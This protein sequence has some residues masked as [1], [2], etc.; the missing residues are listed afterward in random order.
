MAITINDLARICKVSRGTVDRAL[1]D[2]GGVSERTREKIRKA[3]EEYGYTP[4]YIASSLATGRSRSV[5]IIVFDLNN[6]FFTEVVSAAEHEFLRHG[7]F[8]YICLSLKDRRYEQ[9]LIADLVRRKA[10]GILFLP[11]NEG[12]EFTQYLK[13][14]PVPLVAISNRING[15]PY[16]G[17]D[18]DRAVGRGMECFYQRG[19]RKVHFVCPPL[20][21]LGKENLYSQ[22][23]R[24]E[25]Y[26]AYREAHPDMQG[27]EIMGE[28]YLDQVFERAAGDEGR[29]GFFCSSDHYALKIIK[30][31]RDRGVGIPSRFSLMGFDGVDN[32]LGHLERQLTTISYPAAEIG[33]RA[34]SALV[35]QI[36]GS[37]PQSEILL[38]CPLIP[39]ETV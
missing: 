6:R 1:H 16:I 10:D 15:L 4:N 30:A 22:L 24:L 23:R 27:D 14:L 5:G 34:A 3:A 20:R 39:G 31:A 32:V 36:N 2:R 13:R 33:R 38:E 25:G 21:N 11:V 19:V 8:S 28:D 26:R 12:E 37:Q 29:M 18:D 7:L 35:G 9:E 17:G